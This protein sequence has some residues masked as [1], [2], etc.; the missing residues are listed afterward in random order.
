MRT[1]PFI[2]NVATVAQQHFLKIMQIYVARQPIFNKSKETIAYELLFRDSMSNAFPDVDGETATSKVLSNSFFTIGIEQL[3]GGK[4]S[5]INFTG[6]LLLKKIPTMFPRDRV[7]VEILENIEPTEE[8]VNACREIAQNGYEIAL[9]DFSYRSDLDPLIKLAEIIKI[10]FR[11]TPLEEIMEI[12]AD[13]SPYGVKFLAEKV[14]T[15]EEFKKALELGFEYF[16]GYFFSKPEILKSEDIAPAKINLLQI[17]SE[18]NKDNFKFSNLEKLIQRDLSISYK[19]MRYINSAYFRRVRGISSIR[20]AITLL[21][22][23]DIRRFISLISMANLA[24][25]KPD[26]LTRMSIIRA[27]LCELIGKNSK[28]G[29]D[30]SEFFT[31]GLF[32]LIDAIMDEDIERLMDGLPLSEGI[33]MALVEKKGELADYLSVVLAYELGDWERF[34]ETS[35]KIALDSQIVPALYMDSV[36][37][38]DNLGNL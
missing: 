35:L 23:I 6:D 15:H 32:S 3:S 34:C 37:W 4:K 8:I 19:L 13:L 10:D 9:D 20:Q 21:G 14:E 24:V 29:A 5:F 7:T 16:Q 31:L 27:R 11:L 2:S 17:I 26:E 1:E 22:E 38:A 12:V 28:S 18:A 25:D 36:S 30:Q 33:K